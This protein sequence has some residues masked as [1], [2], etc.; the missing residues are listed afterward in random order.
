MKTL[1]FVHGTGVREKAFD[2]TRG[3]LQNE[4][5]NRPIA[6]A[7]YRLEGC[8]WGKECG[9]QLPDP[10]QSIPNYAPGEKPTDQEKELAKWLTLRCDHFFELREVVRQ[11]GP[12]EPVGAA[13]SAPCAGM[14]A[15][16]GAVSVTAP[17]RQVL[18]R[19]GIEG[20]F[21]AT[22]REL[23]ASGILKSLCGQ[24]K[25]QPRTA[26]LMFARMI[27]ARTM[28]R[29][30]SD[31]LV[32]VDGKIRD[33]L[34][35]LLIEPLGGRAGAVKEVFGTA[36]AVVWP[37]L[38]PGIRWATTAGRSD[39]TNG[40]SP[41]A[42]DIVAYQGP[43]GAKFRKYILDD[44]GNA[45]TEEV[46]LVAHSLGGIAC[47]DLLIEQKVP[48]VT[49]LITVGSQAPFLYEMDALCKL[50]YGQPLPDHFPRHWMNIYDPHDVLAYRA[51][52]VFPRSSHVGVYDVEIDTGEAFPQSHGAY[53]SREEFW[54][55]MERFLKRP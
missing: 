48:K 11:D 8:Y 40:G 24:I 46:A 13:R 34:V 25:A 32:Q 26:T 10:P 27:V 14:P 43:R 41:V 54:D 6:F 35:E 28:A 19:H 37:L 18:E 15:V 36:L 7:G 50:R 47:V 52:N 39:L 5:N 29:A 20:A 1:L 16:I 4:L 44:I 31:L 51:E 30:E 17:L 42:G 21:A 12:W 55:E 23:G 33:R 38:S 45:Q 49:H 9:V 3:L 2:A 53:W 22:I